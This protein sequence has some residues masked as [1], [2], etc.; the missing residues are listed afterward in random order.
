M[1]LVRTPPPYRT[2]SLKGYL[3]R[4]SESNG[5][6]TPWHMLKLAGC[7]ESQ[8]TSTNFPIAKLAETL[9]STQE[10]LSH[11]SYIGRGER[12]DFEWLGHGLSERFASEFRLKRMAICPFCI[13]EYGHIDAFFDL[14]LAVA[15]PIHQCEVITHCPACSSAL[16]MFRPGLLQCTCG[17]LLNQPLPAP[18]DAKTKDLMAILWAK[19]HR[20]DLQVEK[21]SSD[22]PLEQ[23]FSLPLKAFFKLKYLGELTLDKDQK[24]PI[25]I[26]QNLAKLLAKWPLGFHHFLET[27]RNMREANGVGFNQR[28]PD[29]ITRYFQKSQRDNFEWLHDEFINY[30]LKQ[31]SDTIVDAKTLRN[32]P[33]ERR[34]ISKVELGQRLGISDNTIKKL[35]EKNLIPIQ[36]VKAGSGYRYIADA[37]SP[38]FITPNTPKGPVLSQN[39]AAAYI[40]LTVSFLRFLKSRK[41]I[42]STHHNIHLK[43]YSQF[44]LDIFR[45]RLIALSQ[46]SGEI[47]SNRSDIVNLAFVLKQ[48]QFPSNLSRYKFLSAYLNGD[49]RSIGRTGNL[50]NNIYLN[51]IDA[52]KF[53]ANCRIDEANGSLT[54]TE[55]AKQLCVSTGAIVG[56]ISNGNLEAQAARRGIRISNKSLEEFNA[57]FIALNIIS[58]ETGIHVLAL[59]KL[60]ETHN[61]TLTRSIQQGKRIKTTAFIQ[62]HHHSELLMIVN[63]PTPTATEK[64][65]AVVQAL[66]SYIESLNFRGASLPSYKGN[67]NMSAIAKACG[68][69]RRVLNSNKRLREIIETHTT[70]KIV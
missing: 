3:L 52:K 23:L 67:P 58:D 61:I 40:G 60:C 5:Y 28:F 36:R 26:T 39:K 44:D 10:A 8:M 1:M 37:T 33:S 43:G 51:K 30:G 49:I 7:S 35:S 31:A 20:E 13:E 46:T 19:V 4:I 12:G 32:R 34:F 56:L 17:R 55:A 59:A 22:F 25:S 9:G 29:L 54:L 15:C 62:R 65:P 66:N 50:I 2:E 53:A 69:S 38:E 47:D 41:L 45:E 27:L 64:V 48:Y 68:F 16:T 11:I 42:P 70:Q 57:N 18:V 63:T 14:K 24:T 6:L 21:T